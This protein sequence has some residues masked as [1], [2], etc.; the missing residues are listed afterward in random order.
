L[1]QLIGTESEGIKVT[2]KADFGL[3]CLRLGFAFDKDKKKFQHIFFG[4]A[5]FMV[6]LLNEST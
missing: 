4:V 6:A 2:F 1:V 3:H 5:I